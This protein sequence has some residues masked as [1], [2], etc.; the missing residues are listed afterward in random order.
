[1]KQTAFKRFC[2]SDV[3]KARGDVFKARVT[4]TMLFVSM[5]PVDYIS[6]KDNSKHTFFKS[7]TLVGC[8]RSIPIDIGT[9]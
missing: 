6:L 9:R 4:F 8:E 5:F 3:F 1:M 2:Q 7:N